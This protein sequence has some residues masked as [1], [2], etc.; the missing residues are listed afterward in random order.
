MTSQQEPTIQYS[1]PYRE[2]QASSLEPPG[3]QQQAPGEET[4]TGQ[5]QSETVRTE[6]KNDE[7]IERRIDDDS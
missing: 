4:G 2:E 3:H 5:K 6:K 7:K 1:T